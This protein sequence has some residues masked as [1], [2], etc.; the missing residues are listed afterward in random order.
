MIVGNNGMTYEYPEDAYAD[1]QITYEEFQKYLNDPS[2]EP[3]SE[4]DYNNAVRNEGKDYAGS[5]FDIR[6]ILSTGANAIMSE[7]YDKYGYIDAILKK[8]YQKNN[9]VSELTGYQQSEIKYSTL[10]ILKNKYPFIKYM[11]QDLRKLGLYNGSDTVNYDPSVALAVKAFK[12]KYM[13][14]K[15][16]TIINDE[17]IQALKAEAN[18]V[19]NET[20]IPD[21][22]GEEG[23]AYEDYAYSSD[24]S[25]TNNSGAHYGQFFSEQNS[26]QFRQNKRDIRIVLGNGTV[27]KIIKEVYMRSVGTEVDA[28]G[29]PIA[30]T[31]EFIAR[32]IIETDNPED[33]N[34]Y[35]VSGED[36][37]Q[38]GYAPRIDFSGY[39]G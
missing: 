20:I 13:G 30:E 8:H 3:K 37:E 22:I 21:N 16:D 35:T 7:G 34:G 23:D 31:Y 32:D 36:F 1:G 25:G 27:T 33:V 10:N 14:I 29:N 5:G 39:T 9:T 26:K 2:Y 12:I 17:F 24:S 28:S 38:L 15:G 4:V 18:N 19:A 6:A 11:C